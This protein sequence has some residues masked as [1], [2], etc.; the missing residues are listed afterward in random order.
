[1]TRAAVKEYVDVMLAQELDE[2]LNEHGFV[3]RNRSI[4]YSRHAGEAKQT[5]D[6]TYDV[7]PRYAGDADAH[8]LPKL[9]ILLPKVNEVAV[10]MEGDSRVLGSGE[11]TLYQPIEF[12]APKIETP[13]WQPSGRNGF[14]HV[15]GEINAFIKRWVV[16]FLDEYQTSAAF[17]RG[18]EQRDERLVFVQPW[19]VYVAAAYV[20]LGDF[21]KAREVIET[22]LGA[23]GLRKRYAS[24]F[25][26]FERESLPS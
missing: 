9:G 13:R 22:K 6:I 12:V 17:V 10:R 7:G 18:Y 5:I 3:R 24:V 15:G 2:S 16:P 21:K 23:P 26:Y 19:Y 11:A 8:I 20:V 14:L 25:E 1:M 4:V